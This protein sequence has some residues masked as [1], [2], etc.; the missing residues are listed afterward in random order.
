[1][2]NNNRNRN[3]NNSSKKKYYNY[4]ENLYNEKSEEKGTHK[5]S[6]PCN[7]SGG[8]KLLMHFFFVFLALILLRS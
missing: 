1:M 6:T 7:L 5:R 8:I 2:K 3:N 4:Q